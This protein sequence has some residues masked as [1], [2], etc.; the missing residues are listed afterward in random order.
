MR[1]IHVS[2]G[3]D[4]QNIFERK[5]LNISLP[6]SF[7]ICFG[8]SLRRFLL[9]THNIYFGWEIK[10]IIFTHSKLKVFKYLK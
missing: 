9:S 1:A 6:I 3:L 8:C 7:N 2:T 10:K 4:K 5:I